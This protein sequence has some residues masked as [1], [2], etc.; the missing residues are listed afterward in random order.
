M[1]LFLLH[2]KD[3]KRLDGGPGCQLGRDRK[4]RRPRVGVLDFIGA[5]PRWQQK[6]NK[7]IAEGQLWDGHSG[8]LESDALHREPASIHPAFETAATTSS[9]PPPTLLPLCCNRHP[10]TRSFLTSTLTSTGV[11]SSGRVLSSPK[12]KK[13]EKVTRDLS[14]LRLEACGERRFRALAT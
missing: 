4:L 14:F 2:D 12:K 13:R 1:F 8:N 11:E 6:K 5:L 7:K 9:T 10:S 3:A